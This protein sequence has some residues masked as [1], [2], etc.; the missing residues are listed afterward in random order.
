[1]ATGSLSEG[2]ADLTATL[3]PSGKVLIAGGVGDAGYLRSVELYDPESGTFSLTGSVGKGRAAGSA[4]LLPSGKVLI[5]GGIN[6]DD[7]ILGD[8]E[9]YDPGSGTFSV[10]GRWRLPA[11]GT[12]GYFCLRA[13][14]S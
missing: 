13:R 10:T 6:H 1:M 8:A 14:S 3:L 7:Q 11:M 2:R 9:L 4:T 5:A 12:Q